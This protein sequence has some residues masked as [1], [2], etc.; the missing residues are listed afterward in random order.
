MFVLLDKQKYYAD[1]RYYKKNLQSS[2]VWEGGT[3]IMYQ[4]YYIQ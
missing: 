2:F 1:L 4:C 3:G